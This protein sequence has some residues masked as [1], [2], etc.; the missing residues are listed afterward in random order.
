MNRNTY[1]EIDIDAIKRN[2]KKI[3]ETYKEYPYRVAVVKA[4]SYGHKGNE[5][6][7]AILKAGANFLAVSFYEEALKIREKWKEIPIVLLVPPPLNKIDDCIKNNISITVLDFEYLSALKEKPIKVHLRLDVGN[8]FYNGPKTKEELKEYVD[9]IKQNGIFLEALYMHSY[10]AED[11]E[12]T[13]EGFKKFE[14]MIQNIDVKQIPMISVPNSQALTNYEKK[15]YAN[16]FRMGNVMY[17][18]E[19]ESLE[20]EDTFHLYSSVLSVKALKE[21]EAIGYDHCYIAEKPSFIAIIP[22]GYGDGF[23]KA[24][25]GNKVYINENPYTIVGI[26]MD[27]TL[28]EVDSNVHKGDL[29]TIIKG[30]R[31]LDQIA[32]HNK[33]IAEEILCCLNTRIPRIYKKEKDSIEIK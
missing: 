4:D 29:C 22:I 33:S 14:K 24:N 1:I 19:N 13:E 5:V 8:D 20:L 18:I 16:A 17:G 30:D 31:H 12:F 11:K 6:V 23:T 28:V 2:V 32:L 26:T 21:K 27:I 9:F 7:E 15:E 10:C 3:I 25:I